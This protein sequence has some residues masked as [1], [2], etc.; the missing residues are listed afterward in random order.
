MKIEKLYT[1]IG[2]GEYNHQ[3]LLKKIGLEK[4]KIDFEKYLSPECKRELGYTYDRR[5][6]WDNILKQPLT[7]EMVFNS[8]EK[9][10][11]K[12]GRRYM[13]N[14]EYSRWQED[15]NNWQEAETKVILE[16]WDFVDTNRFNLNEFY[17]EFIGLGNPWLIDIGMVYKYK[18]ETLEDLAFYTKGR[19]NCKNLEV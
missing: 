4:D 17:I 6:R 10:D 19:L 5:M 7:K 3:V 12:V 16:G 15:Y 18:L 13:T 9:P 1:S 8:F 11:K 14:E 2:F